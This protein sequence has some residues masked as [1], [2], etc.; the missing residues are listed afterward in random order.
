MD[1]APSERAYEVVA[2]DDVQALIDAL[3]ARSSTA[4]INC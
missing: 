1:G 4:G 3:S 2:R